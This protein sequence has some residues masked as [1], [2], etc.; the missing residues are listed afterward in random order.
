MLADGPGRTIA[1]GGDPFHH[2]AP[3][4]GQADLRIANLE[5][6]IAA[7]GKAVDKPWTFLAR[8]SVL[9]VLKRHVDVVSV[10]NNHSGDF[11]RDAF[12]EMLGRL[13][14][15][16]LPY[17]GGGPDLR[18]AH[19]PLVVERKGVRIALLGYNHFFPRR[20]EAGDRPRAWP[21]PTKSRWRT[22]LRSRGSRP[23]S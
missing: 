13:D 2:V 6:V 20:F 16:G 15:A 8:P 10:A 19:Q 14:Q 4:L 9:P 12:A 11:G 21:G 18:H 5:C 22:T 7:K 23:M 17:F 3:L 1:R